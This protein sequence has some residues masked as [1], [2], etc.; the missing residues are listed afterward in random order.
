MRFLIGGAV[1]ALL[2]TTA[3]GCGTGLGAGAQG[4][5]AAKPQR[6]LLSIDQPPAEAGKPEAAMAQLPDSLTQEE[7]ASRLVTIEEGQVRAP[8]AAESR[9]TQPYRLGYFGRSR[10]WNWG[11]APY[12]GSAWRSFSYL[13]VGSY[14]FPYYLND[15][16]FW[17]YRSDLSPYFYNW[18]GSFWP[19]YSGYRWF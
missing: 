11:Y 18:R 17:R 15:G 3:A 14:L 2:A 1:A 19:Y 6:A 9:A 13:P 16:R 5:G 12:W 8:Q 10:F 4:E 7:A